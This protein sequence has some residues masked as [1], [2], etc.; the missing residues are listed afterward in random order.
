MIPRLRV[1]FKANFFS[2]L[3]RIIAIS[4]VAGALLVYGLLQSESHPASNRCPTPRMALI[5]VFTF[6]GPEQAARRAVL[7]EKYRALN[8]ELPNHMKVDVKFLFGSVDSYAKDME[9]ATEE[10]LF[11]NETVVLPRLEGRDT[12][13]LYDWFRF[14]H[15]HTLYS[16][17]PV[18]PAIQ[19]LKYRY[20]GKADDDAVIHIPRLSNLLYSLPSR[21]PYFI[22]REFF[23][24]HFHMTGML[25]LVS[26]SVASWIATSSLTSSNITGVEDVRMG[27]WI[28]SSP[29][30]IQQLNVQ[31]RFHDLEESSG[32]PH[33]QTTK[34]SIVIHWC[35]DEIRL[36]RCLT[37]LFSFDQRHGDVIP[38]NV[39]SQ[40]TSV[41]SIRNRVE[42]YGLGM[43]DTEFSTAISRIQKLVKTKRNKVR[44]ADLDM[45]LIKPIFLIRMQ[46]LGFK[47]S[48]A[49]T[50][51]L[52][53]HIS[54]RA[55][56][57]K[58]GYRVI[59]QF[60]IRNLVD[61]RVLELGFDLEKFT[62]EHKIL[63]V[64]RGMDVARTGDGALDAATLDR[65]LLRTSKVVLDHRI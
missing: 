34:N 17:H 25:Y 9:I 52:L 61:S 13:K 8:E 57:G 19:C 62:V 47:F 2:K 50:K 53:Y 3:L 20:I 15:T 44:L 49:R 23:S 27:A 37:N 5:A 32:F 63:A 28:L 51:D 65:I 4:C 38:E 14:V 54:L 40:F 64:K 35:K 24:P 41:R 21:V 22:G 26:S 46:K 42:K 10:Y 29:F 11:P 16:D 18:T 60:I 12:G 43:N 1:T 58:L 30:K 55:Y 7:R 31:H 6:T 45:I 39:L 36:F 48:E 59:D 56:T 33:N